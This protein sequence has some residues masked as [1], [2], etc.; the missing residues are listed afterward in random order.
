MTEQ[1]DRFLTDAGW[2]G[3]LRLPL[4]GDASARRYERLQRGADRAVLM[5]SPA[6]EEV[7][8][9]A[10]VGGWLGAQGY[11]AP[12][13]LAMD[14]PQGLMLL[15]DLGDD[16]LFTLLEQTPA[17][18]ASLYALV[19]DFLLDLHRHAPP[20]FVAALDGPALA[21]LVRLTPDWAP[22]HPAGASAAA[23]LADLVR[24]QYEALA[25]LPPV[26]SLRDFHAQNMLW[27]PE[28]QGVAQLGLL[29]FQDA[30]AA[31]PAYDLVSALQD[32]RHDVSPAVAAQEIARY[33]RQ[34]GLDSA[35]AR[36]DFDTATALLGAQRALR[37]HGIFARLCLGFGKADYIRLMPRN[38][39]HLQRNLEHP[40]LAPLA[41]AVRA[42]LL[43]PDDE[44][45]NR[46]IRQCATRPTP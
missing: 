11:S 46:L 38:W 19:T 32:V 21:D 43:P 12:Q 27:L 13:I 35:G 44:M 3:A 31:H 17:R 9:F 45:M 41:R 22:L 37:I 20:D 15:E 24:A 10:R 7:A 42:A 8:R 23:E 26:L 6:P 1:I 30:V 28:R 4:A 34:R 18:E 33:I 16:L 2:H 29:D 5:I 25:P 36:R 14:A 39:H 40:A